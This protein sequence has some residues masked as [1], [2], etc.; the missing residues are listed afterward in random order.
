MSLL[1]LLPVSSK[2]LHLIRP[3][4][5]DMF[6][7]SLLRKFTLPSQAFADDFK[8]IADVITHSKNIT[9]NEIN[10]VVDWVNERGTPLSIEKCCV[11]HCSPLQPYNVY[12][13]KSTI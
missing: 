3:V 4:L 8:F 11:L 1:T 5:C 6:I 13:I 12:H 2:A 7:D 10:I 9:Q